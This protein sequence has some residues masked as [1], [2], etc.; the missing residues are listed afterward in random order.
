MAEQPG[1]RPVKWSCTVCLRSDGPFAPSGRCVSC[2]ASIDIPTASEAGALRQIGEVA[3]LVGL[4]LRTVRH[5][6]DSGL[7]LP[8]ARTPGGF[9]LY[10]DQAVDRLRLIMKM[11]PLGFTLEEMRILIE[12]RSRLDSGAIG[13]LEEQEL[14]ERLAMFTTAAT[15]KVVQ[16]AEQLGIAESF[17]AQL[18]DDVRRFGQSPS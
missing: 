16:L 12:T 6:E 18:Q 14:R 11:K 8:A 10:D 15:E 4:S 1:T 2:E 13:D 7:V 3:N 9:R 17:V 5:Y